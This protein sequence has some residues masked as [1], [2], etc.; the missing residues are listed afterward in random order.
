MALLEARRAPAGLLLSDLRR[1]PLQRA[2]EDRDVP[3]RL[4]VRQERATMSVRSPSQAAL[5][6]IRHLMREFSFEC[7]HERH[8]YRG[9]PMIVVDD[10]GK[11]SDTGYFAWPDGK[12]FDEKTRPV[13]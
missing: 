11:P 1:R 13:D 10:E 5:R 7:E 2:A 3:P 9:Q 6:E 12:R 8:T 4:F